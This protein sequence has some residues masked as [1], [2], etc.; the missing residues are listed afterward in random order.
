[1]SMAP[2]LFGKSMVAS[3]KGLELVTKKRFSR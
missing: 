3:E 1:M 2:H